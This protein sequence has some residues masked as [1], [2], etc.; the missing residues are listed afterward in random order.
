M[1][2]L[3]LNSASDALRG[4]LSK[5]LL[6]PKAGVM[7]GKVSALVRE[8][9]WQMVLE[10]H[11]DPNGA[12]MIYSTNTEQGFDIKIMGDPVRTVEDFDGILLIK[13]LENR[14]IF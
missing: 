4:E 11:R 9:L 6:E 13:Y 14:D 8:K 2:I 12:V 7:V 3:V 5:W 1:V 10:N